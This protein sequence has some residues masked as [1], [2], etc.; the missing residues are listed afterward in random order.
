VKDGCEKSRGS[1][2]MVSPVDEGVI[3]VSNLIPFRKTVN[4]EIMKF[5]ETKD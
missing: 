5:L 2:R 4:L 3:W 1:L